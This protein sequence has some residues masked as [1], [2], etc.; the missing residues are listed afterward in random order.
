MHIR[1]HSRIWIISSAFFFG[2]P[3]TCIGIH[4]TATDIRTHSTS[5]Q[6]AKP[7]SEKNKIIEKSYTLAIVYINKYTY[8]RN[9]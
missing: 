2:E 7:A 3:H 4:T 6:Q 1:A 8:S 5:Q 9:G